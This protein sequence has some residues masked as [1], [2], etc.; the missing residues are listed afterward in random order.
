M[1]FASTDCTLA[2]QWKLLRHELHFY[3]NS[4]DNGKK[5]GKKVSIKILLSNSTGTNESKKVVSVSHL[6]SFISVVMVSKHK[7]R[8]DENKLTHQSAIIELS[9]SCKKRGYHF[10]CPLIPLSFFCPDKIF[11]AVEKNERNDE[12]NQKVNNIA[13]FD[14]EFL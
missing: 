10:V 2:F 5:K 7:R 9:N 11:H 8:N 6:G 14:D 13:I 3:M 1:S 12:I 4:K